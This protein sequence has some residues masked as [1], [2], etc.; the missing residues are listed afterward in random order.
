MVALHS[1]DIPI[2]PSNQRT[3]K[4]PIT[5][6]STGIRKRPGFT[7]KR[8]SDG[9]T[10]LSIS[11]YLSNKIINTNN[12]NRCYRKSKIVFISHALSQ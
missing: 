8:T 9:I 6:I 3:G 5:I 7:G 11:L 10:I 2:K 12:M 1:Q 4:G